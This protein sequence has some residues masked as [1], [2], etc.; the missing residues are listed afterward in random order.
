MYNPLNDLMQKYTEMAI[1]TICKMS[2]NFPPVG[3]AFPRG[4]LTFVLNG[5]KRSSP[6]GFIISRTI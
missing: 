6:L 4:N 2:S 5:Q 1:R 3:A